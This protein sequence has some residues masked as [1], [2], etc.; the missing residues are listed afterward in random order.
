MLI[1]KLDLRGILNLDVQTLDLNP[2]FLEKRI[3]IRT[4]SRRVALLVVDDGQ[5]AGQILQTFHLSKL[6]VNTN[7]VF[8]QMVIII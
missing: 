5:E 7:L 8:K 3:R 1:E 4:L 6:L 2:I